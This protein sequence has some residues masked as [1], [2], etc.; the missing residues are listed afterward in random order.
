MDQRAVGV[1][2]LRRVAA[3]VGELLD[4]VLV[5]VPELV[6]RDGAQAKGTTREVLDQV[7]QRL[8]GELRLVRPRRVAEYAREPLGIGRLDRTERVEQRPTHV[9]GRAADVRPVCAVRDGEAVVGG[10]TRVGGFACL[11]E[12]GAVLLVPDVRQPLEE[13]QRE[14]VLLVVT[15]V[16]QSPEQLCRAPEIRLELPL[17]QMLGSLAQETQPSSIS[18]ARSLSSA[19]R[20]SASAC[21]KATT[22]SG[23]GGILLLIGGTT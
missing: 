2:L 4:Q 9:P 10:R 20:A 1:E 22:A 5:A 16:D 19:A 23:S 18:T 14:D 15:R 21:S 13:E 11:L 6:L 7:L 8:V 12:R 3:V 17:A